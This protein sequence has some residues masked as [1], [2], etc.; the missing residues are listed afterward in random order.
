MGH[1]PTDVAPDVRART[2]RIEAEVALKGGEEGVLLAHGDATSGYSLYVEDGR[3]HHTLNIGGEKTT[4]TSTAPVP[5]TATRLGVFASQSPEGPRTFTLLID[6]RP[7][8]EVTATTGFVTFVSWSGLDI[9]L[10]RGSPVAD[11][12]APF[13]FTGT[14]R[15]VTVTLDD[16]QALDGEAVGEAELAR[17]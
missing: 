5:P 2:Y 14:L 1:L 12:P 10:D 9:G 3:L 6:G 16:D 11:Y 13:A 15:K 8:G 4:V 7:A 17:Q